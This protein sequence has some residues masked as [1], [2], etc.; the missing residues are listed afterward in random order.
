VV[1]REI[2]DR[3]KDRPERPVGDDAQDVIATSSNLGPFGH[4]AA[5]KG[6]GQVRELDEGRQRLSDDGLLD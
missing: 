6:P 2:D 5:D 1:A 3:L 4:V